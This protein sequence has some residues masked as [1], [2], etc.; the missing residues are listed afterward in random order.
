MFNLQLIVIANKKKKPHERRM[1]ESCISLMHNNNIWQ[2]MNP[3][4][5][6]ME[7]GRVFSRYSEVVT[8]PAGGKQLITTK[9]TLWY[10]NNNKYTIAPTHV[11]PSI[12]LCFL[13]GIAHTV[14]SQPQ[15]KVNTCSTQGCTLDGAIW[16]DLMNLKEGKVFFF[17]LKKNTQKN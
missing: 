8:M 6:E 17:F 13:G 4:T 15:Q 7:T 14:E 16:G 5:S 10:L 1:H 3:A 2:I 11:E 12:I 9:G